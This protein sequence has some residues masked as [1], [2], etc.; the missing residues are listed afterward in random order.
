M[1]VSN[2]S[3]LRHLIGLYKVLIAEIEFREHYYY[4]CNEYTILKIVT[5]IPN[6]IRHYYRIQKH[7]S[8]S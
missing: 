8:K 3:T 1:A 7:C 6:Y 4:I 2:A 5:N